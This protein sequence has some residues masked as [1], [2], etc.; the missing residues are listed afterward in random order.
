[1]LLKAVT[2]WH[3]TSWLLRLLCNFSW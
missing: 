3:Q 2:I 1:L